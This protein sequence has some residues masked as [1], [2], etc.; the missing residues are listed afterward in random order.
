MPNIYEKNIK[1]EIF[2]FGKKN[3]NSNINYGRIINKE[4]QP[5]FHSEFKKIISDYIKG[6]DILLSEDFYNTGNAMMSHYVGGTWEDSGDYLERKKLSLLRKL[7][8][9]IIQYTYLEEFLQQYEHAAYLNIVL[10]NNSNTFLEDIVVKLEI[11]KSA[12]DNPLSFQLFDLKVKCK[13]WEKLLKFAMKLPEQLELK[14]NA[15]IEDVEYGLA[16]CLNVEYKS[17]EYQNYQVYYDR[18]NKEL[19]PFV[20]SEKS[21]KVIIKFNIKGGLRQFSSK[22]LCAPL[23]LNKE[24]YELKYYITARNL[25]K[26]IKGALKQ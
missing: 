15:E 19:Y 2:A 8:E 17:L 11:E 22:F 20:L 18:K 12:F 14:N 1:S 25:N 13:E 23:F 24:I 3:K 5:Y 10:C 21:D 16:D 9:I 6:N 26:E 7:E 4:K